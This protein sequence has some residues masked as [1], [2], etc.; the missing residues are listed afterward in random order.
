MTNIKK[1]ILIVLPCYSISWGG[2]GRVVHDI[3]KGLTSKYNFTIL[4]TYY[5]KSDQL[6][7]IPDGVEYVAFP[8]LFPVSKVWRSY[9]PEI[10]LWL[11]NNIHKYHLLHIHELWLYAQFVSAR[12]A[13]K[14]NI[15]Y[16]VT[17][18]GELD[19]WR[20]GQKAYR[21]KIFGLLFQRRIHQKASCIHALTKFE[22]SSIV[23]FSGNNTPIIVIPNSIPDFILSEDNNT[24][25]ANNKPYILFLGRIQLVKGC[26]ELLKAYTSWIG[27][28]TYD[29]AFAGSFEGESY[30]EL[31]LKWVAENKLEDKVIFKG[32]VTGPEKYNLLKNAS[33]FVLPS[34]SEG[35]SISILEAMKANCPLLVSH[36][37]GIQDV[38]IEHDAAFL[39]DSNPE[40]IKSGLDEFL[41]TNNQQRVELASRALDL[42]NKLYSMKQVMH[43]YEKMYDRFMK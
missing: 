13:T 9:N 8:M 22:E 36:N 7:T 35:F 21:K 42:F 10:A 25:R 30:R 6:Y 18:H 26:F 32:L 16:V 38:L 17:P 3:C 37:I 2:P 12:L 41:Y 40:S 1:N 19:D 27:N 5:S 14:F 39:C 4:T 28:E 29:L 33:L 15:P 20:L 34:F 31:I 43:N 23:S 24:K 11:K